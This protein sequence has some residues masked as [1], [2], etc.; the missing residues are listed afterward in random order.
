MCS[1]NPCSGPPR[2]IYFRLGGLVNR[3]VAQ[4]LLSK[5]ARECA[6]GD[7]FE[8]LPGMMNTPQGGV[9]PQER[10]A[11]SS[12]MVLQALVGYV[13]LVI[14][15]WARREMCADGGKYTLPCF[16]VIL[17]SCRNPLTLTG[18]YKDIHPKNL[19]DAE[20]KSSWMC[21]TSLNLIPALSY[22][23]MEHFHYHRDLFVIAQTHRGFR[24]DEFPFNIQQAFM[25]HHENSKF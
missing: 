20:Y 18:E 1:D 25:G 24:T 7:G 16:L 10:H 6:D 9:Y 23:A 3:R 15:C 2:C 22:Q 19:V 21:F 17:T 13:P 5:H 11:L 14:R 4:I 12:I 8:A